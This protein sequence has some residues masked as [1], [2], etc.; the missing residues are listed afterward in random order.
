MP[1]Y[2]YE[3]VDEKQCCDTCCDGFEVEQSMKE[4]PLASCP[5]CGSAVRRVITSVNIST[6][7]S[8]KSLLSDKNLKKHGFTKLVNEGEGK[9][10]K[11]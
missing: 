4:K 9:F 3:P 7:P 2:I 10:R 11:I 6:S 8:T 5:H 1:T